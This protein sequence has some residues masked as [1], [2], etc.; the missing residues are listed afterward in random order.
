MKCF[1]VINIKKN[2]KMPNIGISAVAITSH[3]ANMSHFHIRAAEI[4]K[5]N[6][7]RIHNSDADAGKEDWIDY[8][9]SSANSIIMS[10]AALEARI[11]ENIESFSIFRQHKEDFLDEKKE[12]AGISGIASKYR[13]FPK[14]MKADKEI[15][16]KAQQLGEKYSIDKIVLVRNELVHYNPKRFIHTTENEVTTSTCN[17]K[18]IDRILR[19]YDTEKK[20]KFHSKFSKDWMTADIHRITNAQ[21]AEWCFNNVTDF[22]KKYREQVSDPIKMQDHNR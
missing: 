17:S 6:A 8:I 12:F 13:D 2:K 11:N 15:I 5:D 7:L 4:A 9:S 21:F 18:N 10:V 14:I 1:E 19:F 20:F 3:M 16:D 22:I